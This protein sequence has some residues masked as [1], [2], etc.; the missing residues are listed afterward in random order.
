MNTGA[1]IKKT[2]QQFAEETGDEFLRKAQE[3]Y[4][5]PPGVFIKK[6]P[7]WRPIWM[8]LG[9]LVT[10]SNGW[11]RDSWDDGFFVLLGMEW[12]SWDRHHTYNRW[13]VVFILFN[14][15]L[16]ITR[17]EPKEVRLHIPEQI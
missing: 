15:G 11:K 12:L 1:H 17:R 4:S 14:V 10:L 8:V 2:A 3:A 5:I 13:C 9:A 7:W 16:V 6:A